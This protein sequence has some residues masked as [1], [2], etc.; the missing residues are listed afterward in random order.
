MAFANEYL[1]K[2]EIEKY[3]LDELKKVQLGHF[4]LDHRPRARFVLNL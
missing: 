3:Q 1:F 2:D 4:L